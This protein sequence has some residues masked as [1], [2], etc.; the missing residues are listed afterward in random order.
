[1]SDRM[2]DLLARLD[3]IPGV[4]GDERLVADAVIEELDGAYDEHDSDV[5]GNHYFVRK[6][7]DGAPTVMLCAHMDELGFIVQHVEDEGFVRLAPI[8]YHDDRMVVD[9]H[10]LI[11]GD[12]GPVLG[13]SG[14]KPS[15]LLEAAEREKPFKLNELA[16]DVGTTSREETEALGVR[17]GHLITFA[18]EGALLNG[19]RVFTGKAV[20]DRAGCAVM[21]EVMRRLSSRSATASVVGVAAVQEELG[22]RGAGPAGFRVQPDVALAIDVTLCGDVPGVDFGRAPIKLGGG[23]AI[24]YFDWAPEV[25]IGN[26]VPRRLTNRLEEAADGAGI[27]YQREV[28]MGGATDAWAISLSGGGVLSGCISLPSRYIHSAVGCVHLDDLEGAVELILAFVDGVT[29]PIE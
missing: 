16:V 18:R 12:K 11:H 27:A 2:L 24:K 20:D 29:G 26:A 21:I 19:T 10:L 13:I 9:Q 3:A 23:P 28:L 25:L 1:M 17:V 14:A 22:I 4:S 5:L 7:G 15:H 6:A 8:G